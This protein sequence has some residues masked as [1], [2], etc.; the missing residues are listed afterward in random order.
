MSCF[1]IYYD[2][3]AKKMRPINNFKEYA[4]IRNSAKNRRNT[5]LA[6]EGNDEAKRKMVQFCYS[7]LPNDDGTLKGSKRVSN[8]VGMDIDFAKDLPKE[9]LEEALKLMVKRVLQMKDDIGLLMLE[10]SATKGLHIVFKRIGWL[11]QEENLEWAQKML[12]VEFD[13]GAK[14]I[15]R[16]FFTPTADPKDLF[17]CKDELFVNEAADSASV[18][19]PS[20]LRGTPPI[21]GG[22][23]NYCH[24]VEVI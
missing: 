8:S 13:K 18:H 7:C 22:E 16:V 4:A 9:E 2:G 10:R 23:P 14:D 1:E 17:F 5:K 24:A 11:N 21:L 19:T 20:P 15:T 6:R 3:G 12:G